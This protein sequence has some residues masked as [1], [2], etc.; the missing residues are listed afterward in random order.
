ML[1]LFDVVY[2]DITDENQQIPINQS[3]VWRNEEISFKMGNNHP[4]QIGENS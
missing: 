2:L 3:L 4:P 1:L